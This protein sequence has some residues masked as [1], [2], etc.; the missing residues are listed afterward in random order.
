ML[1]A[2]TGRRENKRARLRDWGRALLFLMLTDYAQRLIDKAGANRKQ[3]A[4]PEVAM[5]PALAAYPQLMTVAEVAGYLVVCLSSVTGLIEEGSLQAVNIASPGASRPAYR[6]SVAR[7]RCSRQELKSEPKRE[8]ATDNFK[9]TL[10]ATGCAAY[11]APGR[12]RP[13]L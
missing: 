12:R 13:A 6:Y 5:H 11:H 4:A 2:P 7:L 9:C 3:T 10:G 1:T 8:E